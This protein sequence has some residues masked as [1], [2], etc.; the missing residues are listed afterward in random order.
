MGVWWSV[1]QEVVGEEVVPQVVFLEERVLL[2]D[3]LRLLLA[4]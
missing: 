2:L 4:A 3:E 1:Q